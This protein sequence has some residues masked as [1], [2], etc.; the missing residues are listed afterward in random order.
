MQLWFAHRS[1]VSIREQLVTQVVL[2][3]LSDD[4]APGQPLPSTRELARRFHLPP[5]TVSSGYRQLEREQ[6]V[7]L[8][9]GS[10]IFVRESK[11]EGSLSS[12]LTLDQ[13]IANLFR[14]ARKA[15]ALP[16]C[17]PAQELRRIVAVEW[18]KAVTVP[19]RTLSSR[20]APSCWAGEEPSSAASSAGTFRSSTAK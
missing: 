6:W 7:E 13:W 3:I 2:G 8:R 16:A 12:A 14:C 11:L 4:L 10:G 9:R 20:G 17:G 18:Q 15:G 5:N 19:V 1:E